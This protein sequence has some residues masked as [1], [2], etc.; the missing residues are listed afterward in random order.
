MASIISSVTASFI[1]KHTPGTVV[2]YK[3]P[4]WGHWLPAVITAVCPVS[5]MLTLEFVIMGTPQKHDV[6]FSSELLGNI[7]TH[8]QGLPPGFWARPSKTRRGQLAFVDKVTGSRYGT[9]EL[10]WKVHLERILEME[11]LPT[12]CCDNFAHAATD[13]LRFAWHA[14][15]VSASKASIAEAGDIGCS[16]LLG[17]QDEGDCVCFSKDV[18]ADLMAAPSPAAVPMSVFAATSDD[19]C[20]VGK[21]HKAMND[22][23]VEPGKSCPLEAISEC[24]NPL[25]K[26]EKETTS[27]PVD[28]VVLANKDG[29]TQ[30]RVAELEGALEASRDRVRELEAS[31]VVDHDGKDR[32]DGCDVE[33]LLSKASHLESEEKMHGPSDT[34]SR[35]Q[36]ADTESLCSDATSAKE[37]FVRVAELLNRIVAEENLLKKA[38]EIAEL[39]HTVQQTHGKYGDV[40]D[41][42]FGSGKLQ[43]EIQERKTKLLELSQVHQKK[44]Q[45]LE[46]LRLSL[47]ARE[48]ANAMFEKRLRNLE[49][50]LTSCKLVALPLPVTI[51]K[52]QYRHSISCATPP[53]LPRPQL[54]TSVRGR[55]VSGSPSPRG[56]TTPAS[57]GV[58]VRAATEAA[59]RVASMVLAQ[60]G[61]R[62][63]ASSAHTAASCSAAS[64]ESCKRTPH[65]SE[66]ETRT[67]QRSLSPPVFCA[68][69]ALRSHATPCPS[70]SGG[71]VR[72][73]YST[74]AP[75]SCAS[76]VVPACSGKGSQRAVRHYTGVFSHP[77]FGPDEIGLKVTLHNSTEGQWESNE[78]VEDITVHW[79]GK[80]IMISDQ[81]GVMTLDGHEAVGGMLVG[82]VCQNGVRDGRFRL[83]PSKSH[84]PVTVPASKRN[85]YQRDV[86]VP[87]GPQIWRSVGI[88]TKMAVQ[89]SGEIG[90][91]TAYQTS[92]S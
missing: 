53:K 41:C 27:V 12:V 48:Q 20:S 45:D 86:L 15:A 44:E 42:E 78:Q 29:S 10:A 38:V 80:S 52:R 63:R 50:H 47:Q 4:S 17:L 36:A 23:N 70:I 31:L 81:A 26:P 85:S 59:A 9:A 69:R 25:C 72:S 88:T 60:K 16:S 77:S 76:V 37:S 21:T 84:V 64:P 13:K 34:T 91:R 19:I 32:S 73:S 55:T 66:K 71:S 90:W 8:E 92:F 89:S 74:R 58:A 75:S 79:E 2:E 43:Q 65:R 28:V 68:F 14:E 39:R 62:R 40:E 56:S 54:R 46:Q 33:S 35:S 1:E 11:S 30:E 67:P 82:I 57:C 24:S 6:P 51:I 5:E 18:F 49:Q 3:P 22:E 83:V 61:P 7:G 87:E